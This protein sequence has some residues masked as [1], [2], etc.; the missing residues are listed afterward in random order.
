MISS[1]EELCSCCE[2]AE[3]AKWISDMYDV[4]SDEVKSSA[5]VVKKHSGDM[6]IKSGE[7]PEAVYF[8]LKGTAKI[9]KELPD[10]ILYEIAN[11]RAPCLMGETEAITGVQFSR[12]TVCTDS[13]D[14]VVIYMCK[15]VFLDWICKSNTA[16]FMITRLIINKNF[17]QQNKDRAMLFSH[18]YQ[19]LAYRLLSY[20]EDEDGRGTIRLYIP[21][22]RLSE[23]TGLSIRSISRALNSLGKQGLISRHGRSI[24]I[25]EEQADRMKLNVFSEL[26]EQR[27]KNAL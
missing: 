9:Y 4:M 27:T 1:R 26:N 17:S 13:E 11:V 8:L 15:E 10:G 14:A 23:D 5:S 3:A 20:Y 16:M 25:T 6:L 21:R 12:G 2:S 7:T 19:R 22:E 18:G 24:D